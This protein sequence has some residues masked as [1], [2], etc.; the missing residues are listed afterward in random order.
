MFD[1]SLGFSDP[2]WAANV[3]AAVGN[4]GEIYD[5]HIPPLGIER[6]LNNLWNAEVPGLLYAPPY[7]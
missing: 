6:G 7:R 2:E 3:I 4:Y 5:R 1:A